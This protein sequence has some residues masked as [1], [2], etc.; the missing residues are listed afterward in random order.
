[1]RAVAIVLALVGSPIRGAGRRQIKFGDGVARQIPESHRSL[2]G[3]RSG[4]AGD[5]HN[6]RQ[7]QF[8]HVSSRRDAWASVTMMP[9]RWKVPNY[10]EFPCCPPQH[11]PLTR[12]APSPLFHLLLPHP[13]V[14]IGHASND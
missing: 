13:A 12:Y 6:K 8:A 11:Q 14:V 9:D 10:G 7:G 3:E 4:A 5:Q 1:D 2:G